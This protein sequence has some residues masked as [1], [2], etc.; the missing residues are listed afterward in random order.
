MKGTGP[1]GRDGCL[2]PRKG[3][4]PEALTGLIKKLPPRPRARQGT[5][6][7]FSRGTWESGGPSLEAPRNV[8]TFMAIWISSVGYR[9]WERCCRRMRR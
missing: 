9:P 1:G 2:L 5:A 8:P 6:G 3:K 7:S 4:E